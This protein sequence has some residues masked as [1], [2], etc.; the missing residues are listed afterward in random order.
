MYTNNTGGLDP[1]IS[2]FLVI[3][4][5]QFPVLP[6]CEGIWKTMT[7]TRTLEICHG[8]YG[9]WTIYSYAIW[10]YFNTPV[11]DGSLGC[12]CL[13]LGCLVSFAGWLAG[14]LT[15]LVSH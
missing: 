11:V 2:P 3:F 14:W 5:I 13:V 6:V 1:A 8:H 12:L 7:A 15:V 10:H 9:V 4:L